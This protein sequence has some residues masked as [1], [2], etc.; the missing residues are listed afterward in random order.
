MGIVYIPEWGVKLIEADDSRP[1][2]LVVMAGTDEEGNM[3]FLLGLGQAVS[4]QEVIETMPVDEDI[5]V[6]HRKVYKLSSL[7]SQA[8][9]M[10]RI[11][12]LNLDEKLD[13]E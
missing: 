8:A 13:K 3:N 6:I 7:L 12:S 2:W 1:I 10:D 11:N 4:E 5:D 9:M